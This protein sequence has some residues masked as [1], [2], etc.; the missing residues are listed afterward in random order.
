MKPD[1]DQ[2]ASL[3]PNIA[4]QFKQTLSTLNLAAAALVPAQAREQDPKLDAQAALLDQS[5]YRLLR[6]VH[7]LSSAE[8][9]LSEEPFPLQDRDL[10]P[11]VGDIFAQTESLASQMELDLR[12]I[13]PAEHLLCAINKPALEQL[14][15]HLLSNA[16]KFTPAGGTV[17]VELQRHGEQVLLSVSDTG[18]G[19]PAEQIPLLFDR[20]LQNDLPLPRPHGLGLGLPLCRRIAQRHGGTLL[21]ESTPGKGSRFICA[22]PLKLVGSNVSDAPFDYSGGFNRTLLALADALPARAFMVRNQG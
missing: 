2:L 15:F 10:P 20:Y 19:I 7:S 4:T 1:H 14:L 6:M 22:L 16:L 8:Y 3:F 17:T 18:P 21:V 12:L 9:L 13:C 11:L 5:Y